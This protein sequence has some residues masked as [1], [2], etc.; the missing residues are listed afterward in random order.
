M[1]NIDI[2]DYQTRAIQSAILNPGFKPGFTLWIEI[3]NYIK[4]L[5]NINLIVAMNKSLFN[6]LWEAN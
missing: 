2:N 3:K 4:K 6:I 1:F 5:K